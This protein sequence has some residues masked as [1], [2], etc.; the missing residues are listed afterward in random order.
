MTLLPPGPAVR[1]VAVL[2]ANHLGDLVVALPA[3]SALRAA[4]PDAHVTWLGAPLHAE[5][6]AGRPGPW[7]DVVVVPPC[8]GVRGSDRDGPELDDPA[9]Q[10]FLAAQRARGYDLALQLHGGGRWSNPFVRALGA[11]TTAGAAAA[12][13]LTLTPARP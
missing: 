7:D 11:R 10:S 2:R 5:L 8:R 1:R 9:V 3:L 4:H 13:L 12:R 6:L